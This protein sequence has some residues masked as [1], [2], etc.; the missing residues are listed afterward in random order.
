MSLTA[1]FPRLSLGHW[2]TP[3]EMAPRLAAATGLHSLSIK[4]DD[5]SGLGLGGNKIRKLEFLLGEAQAMGAEVVLTTGA[6]QSNHARQTAAAC[7]RLGMKCELVLRHGSRPDAL[8]LENGNVLLDRLFGATVTLIGPRLTRDAVM[9][10]RAACLES[11][12]VRPYCIPVGGSCVTGNL[13]Y[14]AAVEEM[15]S[16][17]ATAVP[18]VIVVPTGSGGTLAG[19][20]T[21]VHLLTLPTRV[22][23]IAVDGTAEGH[24]ALARELA[25]ATLARLGAGTLDPLA[26]DVFGD[27]VGPGYAKPTAG[28][29]AAVRLAARTEALVLDPVYSGKAMAGL[30]DLVR[31]GVIPAD[32]KT[33]FLH[34]GGAPG[35]FA[36]AAPF[37]ENP[38]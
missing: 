8:H 20:L 10:E 34:T 28:M 5:C 7:A 6:I 14:V 18:D 24:L 36:Y 9:A 22:I 13:G 26:G 38:S 1:G 23:G 30:V 29:L 35:L 3:L 33:L 15:A 19:V 32:A 12:G 16:Q 25:N 31:K 21:G 27:Y 2:P 11:Q 17:W 4:R 37:L